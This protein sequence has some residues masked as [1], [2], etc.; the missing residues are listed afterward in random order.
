MSDPEHLAILKQGVH[1]WNHWRQQAQPLIFWR[2]SPLYGQ[3]P[4]LSGADLREADL[5]GINLDHTNLRGA[6]L[7]EANLKGASLLLAD[8]R[9]ANLQRANLCRAR[10]TADLRNADLRGALLAG[11]D[12]RGSWLDVSIRLEG[13]LL[14][15]AEH[16]STRLAGLDWSQVKL[17]AIDWEQVTILGDEELLFAP[18]QPGDAPIALNKRLEEY[19]RL[20]QYESAI[21][22]YESL[23]QALQEQGLP[24]LA[25]RFRE[26][27][28]LLRQHP[29]YRELRQHHRKERSLR[30]ALDTAIALLRWGSLPGG[31]ALASWGLALVLWQH[32]P[33]LVPLL[34]GML[35][36][37]S[38]LFSELRERKP[39]VPR[40]LVL[41]QVLATTG[42]VASI[43]LFVLGPLLLVARKA[44]VAVSL[45][46]SL[47]GGSLYLVSIFSLR[48]QQGSSI[49]AR[50]SVI[51]LLPLCILLLPGL[52]CIVGP[53][54]S[55]PAML[56]ESLILLL[57][58]SSK[59]LI[60]RAQ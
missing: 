47:F 11:A 18:L 40:S 13:V 15:D 45:L 39:A 19:E 25:T 5:A 20:W 49:F 29:E 44:G 1:A 3:G 26:R 7:S 21:R 16:G 50:F 46:L 42:L 31:L 33:G 58:A 22:S 48:S 54:S 55:R 6:N 17:A 57:L 10:V 53:S 9:N 41:A 43:A 34:L 28:R 56:F 37:A 27:A 12:L 52:L 38:S 36:F 14:Q 59:F 32:W 2:P 24:A 35:V 4:D 23:S 30:A 8:L 51:S 60:G